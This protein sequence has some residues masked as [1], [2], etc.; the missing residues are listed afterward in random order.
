LPAVGSGRSKKEAK[1]DAATCI[2]KRLNQLENLS[3][4]EPGPDEVILIPDLLSPYKNMLQDNAVG[5]LQELCMTHEIQIPEYKVIG[6]EGPPHAKQFTIMC[7]V[8]KLV[9]SGSFINP[10]SQ[11]SYE[12]AAFFI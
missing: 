9:E 8:S 4:Q 3:T 11:T 10:S 1:H 5:A 6:D 12:C 2:L 7:Q